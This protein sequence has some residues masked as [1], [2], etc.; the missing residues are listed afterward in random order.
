MGSSLTQRCEITDLLFSQYAIAYILLLF[1]LTYMQ[2]CIYICSFSYIPNLNF[3]SFNKLGAGGGEFPYRV[4]LAC[5]KFLFVFLHKIHHHY[6]HFISVLVVIHFF[7]SLVLICIVPSFHT[8]SACRIH[9][10]PPLLSWLTLDSLLFFCCFHTGN[11]L[12]I[13]HNIQITVLC[14]WKPVKLF[15]PRTWTVVRLEIILGSSFFFFFQKI[16]IVKL[17]KEERQ[18][19][20]MW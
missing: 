14:F 7:H 18:G 10:L 9:L 12:S 5:L 8:L 19:N 1:L 4:L 6:F 15:I 20:G 11:Y 13:V 16:N 3:P 17:T 2:V